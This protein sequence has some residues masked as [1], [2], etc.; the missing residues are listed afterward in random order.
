MAIEGTIVQ[1]ERT[2]TAEQALAIVS[3]YLPE[4]QALG[5]V[6]SFADAA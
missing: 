4:E 6:A 2:P 3:R 5:F 1:T